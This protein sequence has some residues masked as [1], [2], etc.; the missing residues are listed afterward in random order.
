MSVHVFFTEPGARAEVDGPRGQWKWSFGS[1]HPTFT[2]SGLS[3]KFAK[4]SYYSVIGWDPCFISLWFPLDHASPS[5]WGARRGDRLYWDWPGWTDW[6]DAFA[7]AQWA[8]FTWSLSLSGTVKLLR[9]VLGHRASSDL[10]G[11]RIQRCGVRGPI[12][13]WTC[14]RAAGLRTLWVVRE[15]QSIT[16]EEP[17]AVEI[18][19][20]HEMHKTLKWNVLFSFNIQMEVFLLRIELI[21]YMII[22]SLHFCYLRRIMWKGISQN[23]FFFF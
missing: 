10:P 1:P 18:P 13:G 3:V 5:G 7:R 17:E 21:I 14:P 20:S 8:V 6:G 19:S 11:I 23:N 2:R 15:K 16:C 4:V 22:N 12:S 9:L